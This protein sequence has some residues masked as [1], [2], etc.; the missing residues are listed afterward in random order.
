[1]FYVVLRFLLLLLCYDIAMLLLFFLCPLVLL[2]ILAINLS[3]LQHNQ[4]HISFMH[5]V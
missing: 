5:A 3:R 2:V 4:Q 1:M